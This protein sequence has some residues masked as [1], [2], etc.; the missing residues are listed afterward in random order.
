MD[1]MFTCD[2]VYRALHKPNNDGAPEGMSFCF[3]I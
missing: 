3:L 2:P 1:V